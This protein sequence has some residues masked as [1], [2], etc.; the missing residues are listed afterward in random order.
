MRPSSKHCQGVDA[1]KHLHPDLDGWGTSAMQNSM[2]SRILKG[3]PFGGTGFVWNK[4][5]SHSL[6]PRTEYRNER[7]TILELNSTVGSIIIINSYLP[8]FKGNDINSQ[9]EKY[10][11]TIA[12]IDSVMNDNPHASFIIIGDM[13]CNIFNGSNEFSTILTSFVHERDLYCTFDKMTSFQSDLTYTRCNVMQNSFSLLDYVFVSKDLVNYVD[14]VEI[15]DSGSNLSDHLP[16]RV[17]LSIDLSSQHVPVQSP[18]FVVDW[19]SVDETTRR[20]F[21]CVMEDNLN[22][23]HVPHIVH[24][25]HICNS[26]EHLIEIERYYVDII[27]SIHSADLLLPRCRPKTGKGFWNEELTSLKNSS[28][29]AHDLW[30]LNGR[31]RTGPIFDAKKHAHFRF[32]L[33]IGNAKR[34]FNQDRVD[35]LNENLSSGDVNK[36]W[37]SFKYLNGSKSSQ[38]TRID[39][40]VNDADI[41]ERFAQCYKGVY[42]SVNGAQA[43]AL[44]NEF[45]RQ[46]SDYCSVHSGD[47][48]RPFLLSWYDMLDV[49]SKLKAGKATASFVKPEHILYGSP[50]LAFHLHLLFNAMIQHSYVPTDFLKGVVSPLIKDTQGDRTD[51]NNYRPLTLSVLLSNLFEHALLLKISHFLET[52]N[53]QF[54]YKKRH[55]ISHAMYTLKSCID[56]FTNHGSNVF[57]AF[58]DCTKGFDRVNHKGVFIKLMKRGVPLC[59][60]NLLIYWYS[61]LTSVVKW[62]NNFSSPFCVPSGVRQGGVL[63]PYLFVV[64]MDDLFQILRNMKHGCHILDLFVACIMYADDIC[65]LAP[66]RSAL[67]SLLDAC[68]NY[69][70]TW[71]ITYNPLK[72]KLMAFGS[73]ITL[74][75]ISMYGKSLE[76]VDEYKYLGVS[77]VSGA[78]FS[79]SALKPLIKFRSSANTFS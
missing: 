21:E 30:K 47:S 58:L 22:R 38:T 24:G 28:I 35:R 29:A 2:E 74:P 61:N 42:E 27:Q 31:P 33:G 79:T 56:Y 49:M 6:K 45:L 16:I 64:Y 63:S 60:L 59:I 41:A 10:T 18:P 19:R 1:L 76:F 53:L 5:L 72:C 43:D 67:Q 52:D 66:C 50:K 62:N 26:H 77:V 8:Y 68:E 13:N 36:F 78:S 51:P 65:L 73:R 48:I 12:F 71:C 7:V 17:S 55:S 9:T 4:N 25:D 44:S 75:S 3:R 11:D 14:N 54:G 39:N 23:I 37:R 57:I 46:Y 34:E 70:N 69:G 32:K 40:L 20:N 15:I